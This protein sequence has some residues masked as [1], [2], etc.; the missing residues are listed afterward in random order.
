MT[1]TATTLKADLAQFTG[2]EQVYRHMFGMKFTDGVKYMADVAKAY[3]LIDVIASHAQKR[4]NRSRP[5]MVARLVVK[6]GSATFTL[7]EDWSDSEPKKFKAIARQRI[8]FTDFPLESI[9][10][11]VCSGLIML[12]SEY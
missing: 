6:D 12:P 7:H 8:P 11:Y 4:V 1:S 9:K 3:W 10:F 2:T 5:F